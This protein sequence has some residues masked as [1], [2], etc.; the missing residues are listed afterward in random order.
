M[1]S[2]ITFASAATL[3]RRVRE[4]DLSPVEVVDA[5]LSRIE[6]RNA[7]TNAY[8]T[9]AEERAREQARE[10]EAA[11]ERGDDVGP[12]HGVPVAIKDLQDVAGLPTTHGAVPFADDVAEANAAFVDRLEEAGAIVLGKTNTPEFGYKSTTDNELFGPTGTPFDPDRVSGG[13]SGGSAAAVADGLTAFAQGSDGG[14]SIRIP[15]ACCGVYGFKPSFGRVPDDARPDGF[16]HHTPFTFL[17]P[18]TRTVA[19]AALAMDVMAGPSDR[20][21]FSL[22]EDGTAWLDAVDRPVDDLTAAYSPGLDLFPIDPAV[23]ETVEEAIDA[24]AAAGVTVAEATPD[25]DL[26]FEEL[27]ETFQTMY[28][29]GFAVLAERVAEETGF[30]YLGDDRDRASPGLPSMMEIGAD[31]DAVTFARANEVRTRW[32]DAV[33]DLLADYDLLLTPTLAVTPPEIGDEQVPVVD[34]QEIDPYTGWLL[35]WPFNMCDNPGASVPA[36]LVDGLPVGLQV[37]GR[38]HADATV[39][40]ASAAYERQRPWQDTY[41]GVES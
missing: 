5:Y 37:I 4:G 34:G 2:D 13:S 38:R 40:A 28:T 29:A 6:E 23:R 11:V 41:P 22:P 16:G 39:L 30:D 20:D 3:A 36:G 17:G 26:T 27:S 18:M 24:L 35:T 15:S 8:V 14:G 21:P 33:Q 12:L 25:H 7:V 9:V 32:Y 1:P 19:D 31:L 10:A